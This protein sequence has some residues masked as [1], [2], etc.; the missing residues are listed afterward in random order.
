MHKR[1]SI[2]GIIIIAGLTVWLLSFFS[3]PNT[4]TFKITYDS[5]V[6]KDEQD[7][8]NQ[9][10]SDLRLTKPLH[11]SAKVTQKKPPTAIVREIKVPL[12]GHKDLV[13]LSEVSAKDQMTSLDGYYFLDYLD[14]GAEFRILELEGEEA[15]IVRA[16]LSG[17]DQSWQKERLLSIAQTGVTALARALTLQLEAG[18]SPLNFAAEVKSVLA[19]HDLTHVSN[20]VS[21]AD[22]CPGSRTSMS[23]C[24]DWQM[25]EV[26]KAIGTDIV[27]LTGNHNND[28]G[29]EANLATI[30]KYH[31]LG[32]Q[33]FGGGKNATLAA[34]PLELDLKSTK[35]TWLGLNHS[36]STKNNGQG[37]TDDRPGANVYDPKLTET[38]IKQAKAAGRFVIAEVQYFECNEYVFTAENQICDNPIPN[39][40]SFF[41]QLVDWGADLVVGTQAHQPQIFENYQGKWIFYGLGNLF[42][43]QSAWPGTSRSLVLSHYFYDGHYFQTR[44]RPTRYQTDH[45]PR[46]LDHA[47]TLEFLARLRR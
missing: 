44:V 24:A 1:F 39:Q 10:T 41:R 31:Q 33:T 26:L 14:R 25:L 46:F 18:V 34:R 8:I 7:L 43:D 21:F 23:L 9:K 27:A 2:L 36:T 38:Q 4:P 13:L 47:S 16:K 17:L 3:P 22:R 5:S 30:D 6:T 19:V 32:W 45:Q 42:F 20:E 28:Y 35:I 11:I 40:Q 15:D 37:A 12:L 29:P